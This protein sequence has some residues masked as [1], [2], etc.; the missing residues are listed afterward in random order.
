MSS[1]KVMVEGLCKVF[2]SNPRQALDM[3]AQGATKDEIFSRTGQVV[4]VHD[5]SFDVREGEIFVLMG[6][7]GSGKSTL[8]RLIN[9]LVDPTSGKVLVDGRDIAAVRRSELT[10]LRRR[11]MSMVFQSF[12]LMPQRS[13]LSNAAFGLEVAGVR[14]KERE[15]R[16]MTVLEQVGLA[17]FANKLPSE[18]SG[19]M[20]Q[21]VG[22]A[23]ALSVNPSLMIMDEAFSALDPLKRKE[24]QNVLLQLQ[25]EQRRTIMFVSH[26]LEEALRIG[27]RIAIMEGGRLVQLGT[28]QEIISRP[29]DDYVRAFFEGVDTSRYLTAAD[30]MQPDGV[31]IVRQLDAAGVA[32]SLNGSADYAFVLDS[33]RK[34]RG[35]VTRESLGS[36]Q[37]RVSQVECIPCAASLEQVVSRVVAHARALPVVDDDGCYCGSIDRAVV[38]QALTRMRGSH[39]V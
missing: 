38:L 21:R 17:A 16:A 6:L 22:L 33:Q 15:A 24:M 34:P 30:L 4:G 27:S 19:G 11:D 25:K 3:L 1:P 37:P 5:V 14:R 18:L 35:F 39:H 13:V 10:A 23:R 28:P 12:A 26:D 36:T 2:G 31:P 8:I 32:E 7:S 9:R 20:Q 29:A